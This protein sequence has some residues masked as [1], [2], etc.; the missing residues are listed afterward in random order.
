MTVPLTGRLYN[1][2]KLTVHN[3]VLRNIADASD[4]FIYV[5]PHIKK[6]DGRTDIKA[7]RSRYDS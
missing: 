3:I 2:D 5:N 7:L 1:Q 4:A 6:D